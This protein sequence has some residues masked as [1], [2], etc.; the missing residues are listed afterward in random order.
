MK[1]SLVLLLA[2]LISMTFISSNYSVGQS[3]K[4]AYKTVIKERP[5]LTG[6][7]KVLLDS[8]YLL[9]EKIDSATDKSIM[10]IKVIEDSQKKL[11]K[12]IDLLTSKKS[13][14]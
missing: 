13:T 12:K 10:S 1:I 7:N 4:A 5:M 3:Q 8:I 6:K 11:K 9:N 2:L 14:Q